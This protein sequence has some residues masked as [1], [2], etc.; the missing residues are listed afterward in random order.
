MQPTL[1]IKEN[2]LETSLISLDPTQ[3]A[4]LYSGFYI[5]ECHIEG[6]QL[7]QE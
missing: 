7:S 4:D 1:G 3:L 2:E 6:S 5:G